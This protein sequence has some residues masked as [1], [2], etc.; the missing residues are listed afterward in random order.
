MGIIVSKR[1]AVGDENAWTGK[2]QIITEPCIP[3]KRGCV[4]YSLSNGKLL[5][6]F[7]KGSNMYQSLLCFVCQIDFKVQK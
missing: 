6:G 4:F 1:R 7:Y 5:Q 2:D 3:W